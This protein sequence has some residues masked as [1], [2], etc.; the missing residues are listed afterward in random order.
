LDLSE[1]QERICDRVIKNKSLFTF[2]P[3]QKNQKLLTIA[4][5]AGTGKTFL[6]A[7]LA[8]RIRTIKI[9]RFKI[10][11]CCFTGKASSVLRKRL[12]EADALA[13]GDYTGTIHGLIY[14]PRYIVDKQGRKVIAGWHLAKEIDADLII[15]D[16]ASMVNFEIWNDL[17]MYG[18]PIIAV[19]D[20]GQLPPVGDNFNVLENPNHVLTKIHRQAADNPIIQLSMDIR[21]YGYIKPG[22]Y[23]KDTHKVYKFSWKFAETQ[24]LFNK[25]AW[26]RNYI[27]LCGFNATRVKLNQMIRDKYKYTLPEPYPDERVICLKNNHTTKVMNG[28]LGTMVW[29][30]RRAP[31]IYEM[32]I[33]M[34]DFGE[35]YTN[36]VHNC[37]F[38]Q[39]SYDG[40]YDEI[41][42]K[43][44]K[45]IF[46]RT[47]YKTMDLFDYGY[48]ISVH[49]S[50]GSEWSNV[51]LF[52]Q[53]TKHW[54]A[55]YYKRWLYTAVTRAKKNLFVISDFW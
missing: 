34:D 38:G 20:H 2:R 13:R 32:T 4:G 21:N 52:E 23:S 7:E 16:E 51:V 31:R 41:G 19:G 5:Y 50:Q 45:G 12:K 37:C 44:N 46:K 48:C 9:G 6:I 27:I 55:D 43:K 54:D 30:S 26:D 39:D 8:K 22:V 49:R 25:I 42:R 24:R 15:V 47:G 18:V 53:Y 33:E 3:R 14:T 35:F 28:Q 11:F 17:K 29:F 1:E 40:S 36:L 10:A